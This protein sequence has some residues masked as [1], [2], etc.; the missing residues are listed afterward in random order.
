MKFLQKEDGSMD[1]LFSEKEIE[2]FTKT[3][4]LT[5]G[6]ENV[7]HFQNNIMKMVSNIHQKLPESV[8]NIKTIDDHEIVPKNEN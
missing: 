3:K 6:V 1:I 2:I 5:L 8:K 7:R 4:K